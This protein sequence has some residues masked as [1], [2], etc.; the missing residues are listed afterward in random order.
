VLVTC[1]TD[2]DE[3]PIANFS[4]AFRQAGDKLEENESL[5]NYDTEKPVRNYH[6]T[7]SK[8]IGNVRK[9]YMEN[10]GYICMG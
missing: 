2:R 9:Y 6:I 3:E 1:V 5:P 10:G 7:C 8:Y 4:L